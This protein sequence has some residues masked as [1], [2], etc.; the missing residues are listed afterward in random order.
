MVSYNNIEGRYM[1]GPCIFI[2]LL[3]N[4]LKKNSKMLLHFYKYF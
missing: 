4:L 2:Q 3:S 1:V